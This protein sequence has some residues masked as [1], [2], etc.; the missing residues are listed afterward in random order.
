MELSWGTVIILVGLLLMVAILID[1]FRRMRRSRAEALRLDVSNDF[2]FPD[3]DYNPELPGEVRVLNAIDDS[4]SEQP[5]AEVGIS[6]PDHTLNMPEPEAVDID[7]NDDFKLKDDLSEITFD[8]ADDNAQDID[9]PA[10]SATDSVVKPAVEP[11]ANTA[12]DDVPN[13]PLVPAAKPVNLDEQVPVLLDVEE[14]G[15][16]SAIIDPVMPLISDDI[17]VPQD[18]EDDSLLDPQGA[19]PDQTSGANFEETSSTDK[20]SEESTSESDIKVAGGVSILRAGLQAELLSE[21]PDSSVVLIIHVMANQPDGFAGKDL[22]YLFE[23][24]DVRFGEQDIFHRFEQAGGNGRIQFSISQS[25]KPGV[26]DPATF[27]ETSVK[28]LSFF[29]SLPGAKQPLQ[30]YEAMYGM[31]TAIANNLKGDLLDGSLSALTRQTLEHERQQILDF[32]RHQELA[33]KK[34]SRR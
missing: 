22:L 3:E 23:Q 28:G 24:C 17:H 26:F 1:G 25:H 20:T 7:L 30:A 5:L 9:L 4:P 2:T 13:S 10:F 16:D 18:R 12:S 8:A 31:A 14:L 33:M 32:V 29:M 11:D 19:Q 6:D 34:Q 27:G 21:R 15:D